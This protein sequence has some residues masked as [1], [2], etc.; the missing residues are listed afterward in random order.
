MWHAGQGAGD[1]GRNA[2]RATFAATFHASDYPWRKFKLT[3]F[4]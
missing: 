1:G 3:E 4:T 2:T